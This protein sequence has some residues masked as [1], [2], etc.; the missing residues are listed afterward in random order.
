[1]G[2]AELKGWGA[3][4]RVTAQHPCRKQTSRGAKEAVVAA[5]GD[6]ELVPARGKV[7]SSSGAAGG[8]SPCPRAGR[9]HPRG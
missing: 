5:P 2:E 9:G 7:A 3:R 8:Y 4:P 1:M 6:G